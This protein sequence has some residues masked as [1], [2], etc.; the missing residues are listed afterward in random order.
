VPENVVNTV[1]EWHSSQAMAVVLFGGTDGMWP[2]GPEGGSTSV[3]G[4][5]L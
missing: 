2:V 4:A 3:G 5:M 1:G